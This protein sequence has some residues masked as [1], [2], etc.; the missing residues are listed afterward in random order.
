MRLKLKLR[1]KSFSHFRIFPFRLNSQGPE[2][3]SQKGHQQQLCCLF[4]RAVGY[5]NKNSTAHDS[6]QQ[7]RCLQEH[8][9]SSASSAQQQNQRR[10]YDASPVSQR[11]KRCSQRPQRHRRSK[12]RSYV[13][14]SKQCKP[15]YNNSNNG[16]YC[17]NVVHPLQL[18]V[19]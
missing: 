11:R 13:L 15:S 1:L 5:S 2:A 8:A 16:N 6:T 17:K 19:P 10:Q 12:N 14:R 18:K 3:R 4:G 7:Q 9:T